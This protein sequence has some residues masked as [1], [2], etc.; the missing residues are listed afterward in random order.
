MSATDKQVSLAYNLVNSPRVYVAILGA[1]SSAAAGV[2]MSSQVVVGLIKDLAVA[3]GDEPP[4]DWD[5]AAAKTWYRGR[6]GQDPT[7][8]RILADLGPATGERSALLAPNF[9]GT[10]VSASPI[11]DLLAEL[12]KRGLVSAFVTTN[13][14]DLMEQSLQ[15]AGLDPWR[16]STEQEWRDG[17][18]LHR[19]DAVVFH[20]HGHWQNPD[21]MRNTTDELDGYPEWSNTL[22][23]DLFL[24]H[25]KIVIGW[26]GRYDPALRDL[27]RK[28][29]TDRYSTFWLDRSPLTGDARELADDIGA[30]PLI[31]N[32]TETLT[33]VN[34]A[35][36]RL[37]SARPRV[38]PI[39]VD[40]TAVER[41]LDAGNVTPVLREL[42]AAVS[43]IEATHAMR[44]RDFHAAKDHS[45]REL[46]IAVACLEAATI[47]MYLAL[48]GPADA[49]P[50]WIQH[51]AR[52]AN[53]T[54]GASGL[55]ALI[56]Q[57]RLPGLILLAAA[58]V[59]AAARNDPGLLALILNDVRG[60]ACNGQ[61]VS[62]ATMAEAAEALPHRWGFTALN[63]YLARI[64]ATSDILG[65]AEFDI[66]WERLEG[67]WS[68]LCVAH[69][70][71]LPEWYSHGAVLGYAGNYTPAGRSW[72]ARS[73]QIDT[74]ESS[75]LV[76]TQQRM[77]AA[78]YDRLFHES[79]AQV[80]F[81]HESRKQDPEIPGAG[82]RIDEL[83]AGRAPDLKRAC[84]SR[85]IAARH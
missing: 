27:M 47:T 35:V 20:L 1:G 46:E 82:W 78:R 10:N 31:G 30:V 64:A 8:E 57:Q 55:T 67:A 54:P 21:T 74:I 65:P 24:G 11:H 84:L 19:H 85:A 45:S 16:I 2:P 18:P 41:A 9:K 12:A 36:Q 17:L 72:L 83:G 44:S 53:T 28:H 4:V 56:Q 50:R 29:R 61:E 66:A 71:R 80:A 51:A 81:S 23:R 70:D 68:F 49:A 26:S 3:A 60:T 69:N 52:L 76:P 79:A 43:R 77:W 32:A 73:Y 7:Y 58:G 40:I 63:E 13:F 15:R 5:W 33:N 59:G 42:S 39:T 22:A 75:S 48:Y 14:D 6:Y 37:T 38:T 62:L 34:M 25:G